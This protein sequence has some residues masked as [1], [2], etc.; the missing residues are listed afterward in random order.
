MRNLAEPGSRF[1][2]AAPNHP[3]ALLEEPQVFQAVGEKTFEWRAAMHVNMNFD[4]CLKRWSLRS[5]PATCNR[6]NRLPL[7]T[8]WM[9]LCT[10]CW[11]SL[12]HTMQSMPWTTNET[13]TNGS[14]QT[15]SPSTGK[16]CKS[17]KCERAF[18]QPNA[19]KHVI[20]LSV[21]I[22]GIALS[23]FHTSC[24]RSLAKQHWAEV[25]LQCHCDH[26]E[27]Y[28]AWQGK[29]CYLLRQNSAC[30]NSEFECIG[31]QEQNLTSR[32]HL[33]QLLQVMVWCM[34]LNRFQSL[35]SSDQFQAKSRHCSHLCQ[36]LSVFKRHFCVICSMENCHL[37]RISNTAVRTSQVIL[38]AMS[39][40]CLSNC[41][42][43]FTS[44]PNW[45]RGPPSRYTVNN[46]LTGV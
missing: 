5:L 7:D 11:L 34:M 46:W 12:L 43:N 18:N 40:C 19:K 3:E 17:S 44:T 45:S 20:Y 25:A 27:S 15:H 41:A 33:L 1:R 39:G 21:K 22:G 24:R 9:P 32:D 10:T 26:K 42:L 31:A 14:L 6:R 23:F 8:I 29:R 36:S 37:N 13:M 16:P 30:W 38:S 35:T 28:A 4:S 2:A